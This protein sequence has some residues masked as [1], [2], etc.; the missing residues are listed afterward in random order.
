MP[1]RQSPSD[2][3]FMAQALALAEKGR[4][5]VSPNPLVGAVVVKNGKILGKGYHQQFGSAHAEINA[6]NAAKNNTFGATLYVTLEPCTFYGKTP[7]CVKTLI[8]SGLKRVVIATKDPNPKVFG[9]GIEILKKAGI[10]TKVGVLEK[11]AQKQNES[12]FKFIQQRLP[13]VIL[14]LAATLDGKIALSSGESKWID[15]KKSRDFSQTLR[16]NADAI[17]VGV[18]TI[19]KDNPRLTCRIAPKKRLMKV[20]LDSNLRTPLNARVFLNSNTLIF[21]S[22]LQI[23]HNPKIDSLTKKGVKIIPI[24][25]RQGILS[26][27]EVLGELYKMGIG[28]LLIEGGAKV[29]SSALKAKVVDKLFL[30][31]APK[32][33]GKGLSFTNGIK[34]NRLNEAI[35]LKEYELRQ[36]GSDILIEGY[37]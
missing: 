35:K 23:K 26:W 29:C 31:L 32:L 6:L 22:P 4:G 17:L 21:T 15:S 18:N 8:N 7:A 13:F 11:V 33:V 12:Y 20:I 34:S 16:L 2:E 36:L 24:P 30:F 5:F 25:K 14:K 10:E 37:L 9:K 28:T 1:L 27:N 3:F 19:L